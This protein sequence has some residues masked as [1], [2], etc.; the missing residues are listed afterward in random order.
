MYPE[1]RPDGRSVPADEPDR[2]TTRAFERMLR[3]EIRLLGDLRQVLCRQRDVMVSMDEGAINDNIFVLHR[4]LFTLAEARR[5]RHEMSD[6]LSVPET[7]ELASVQEELR[8]AA[9]A[10]THEI[11]TNRQILQGI[12]AAGEELLRVLAGAENRV[13]DSEQLSLGGVLAHSPRG[14]EGLLIDRTI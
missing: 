1:L 8:T 4:L 9:L 12:I 3:F 14:Q 13:R 5:G 10:V 2:T 7:R 11:E 6:L